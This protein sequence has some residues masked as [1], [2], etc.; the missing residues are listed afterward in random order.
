MRNGDKQ[1]K[2][3]LV[4]S[5]KGGTGKTTILAAFALLAENKILVDCDVD[6]ADLHLLLH[7]RVKHKEDFYSG[8]KAVIDPEKCIECGQCTEVCRYEAITEDFKVDR[9]ACEG[10]NACVVVCPVEAVCLV[11]N[12]AGEWYI[13]DTDHGQ[14]VHARLGIAEDN[15]GKLVSHVR[16]IASEMAEKNGIDLVLIDGPPGIGCPVIASMSGIDIVLIVTEPTVSGV[17]DLER[18]LKLAQQFKV[19]ATVCINKF[20]LNSSFSEKIAKICSEYEAGVVG[21]IPFNPEVV[22]ALSQGK[23]VIEQNCGNVTETVI[24]LWET[25]KEKLTDKTHETKDNV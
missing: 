23:T 2:Q 15:S 4:L 16:K 5:G 1:V 6:A 22:K 7:P 17:H 19:P 10:C 20:D 12:R 11:D 25:L 24:N 18:V 3:L 14:M 9:L 21:Q 13:S 8:K